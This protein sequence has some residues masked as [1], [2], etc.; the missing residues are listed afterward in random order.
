MKEYDKTKG[1][2]ID[3]LLQSTFLGGSGLDRGYGIAIHPATGDVYVSGDAGSSDF[4]GIA[5]GA[6]TAFAGGTETFVSRLDST[7]T[8]LCGGC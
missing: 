7:L 6:D 5:G 2:V 4:P 8:T 3:P 1:L